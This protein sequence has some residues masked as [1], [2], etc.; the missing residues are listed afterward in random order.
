M[1]A[2]CS[3]Y[4]QQ[5]ENNGEGTHFMATQAAWNWMWEI[6]IPSVISPPETFN[7]LDHAHSLTPASGTSVSPSLFSFLPFHSRTNFLSIS[8]AKYLSL[9]FGCLAY[10]YFCQ[11]ALTFYPKISRF[12]SLK[13]VTFQGN[14][15]P[16]AKMS[17]VHITLHLLYPI[18][19][20]ALLG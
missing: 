18:I 13:I 9:H 4:Y 8:H 3:N 2:L 11:S 17:L 6:S 7:W 15:M 19:L 10:E 12:S 14:L 5:I 16:T 1:K 20:L